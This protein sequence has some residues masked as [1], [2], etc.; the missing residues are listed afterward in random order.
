[1]RVAPRP[2]SWAVTT[3]PK[4]QLGRALLTGR[5][6]HE[7][8]MIISRLGDLDA[9]EEHLH[10]A[11]DIHGLDRRRTRAIVL[12]DLA[13]YACA[14]ATRMAP[15]PPGASSSTAPKASAP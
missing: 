10:L 7:S 13:A 8:G 11:L 1:M 12:A 4:I 5:W 6:A 2:P 15:W 14:K 3:R 9:A